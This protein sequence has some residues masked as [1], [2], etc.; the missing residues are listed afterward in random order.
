MY[1]R[2]LSARTVLGYI[3]TLANGIESLINKIPG[4]EVSITAGLDNLYNSLD[5]AKE[6]IKDESGW[7]AVVGE[8]EYI[9]LDDAFNR[10]YEFGESVDDTLGN[11]FAFDK[12][13]YDAGFAWDD[14]LNGVDDIAG[15]TAKSA[16][17]LE[18]AEEDIQY[19]RD[20]AERDAINRYTTAEI[21]IEQNNENHISSNMDLDGVIGYLN[22]GVEEAVDIATEGG[23]K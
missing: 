1:S 12:S 5:S 13:A 9:Q 20:I 15:N 19:L 7:K 17:S 22:D 8:L 11:L 10:G 16:K 6:R 14:L 2:T 21:H 4:V 23:H 18:F 3:R